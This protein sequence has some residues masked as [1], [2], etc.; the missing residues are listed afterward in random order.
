[1]QNSKWD[2]LILCLTIISAAALIGYCIL[3]G[4][5]LISETIRAK[6]I[7][8]SS[9]GMRD[10]RPS[11]LGQLDKGSLKPGSKRVKGVSAAGNALKGNPKAGVL[12]VEFSDFQCPFSK[13]F[14]QEVL[15]KIEKEYIASSKVK[16]AYRDFP[17]AFHSQAKLAAMACECAGK[18]GKYWP[19]FDK[20]STS[21]SLEKDALRGFAKGIG[22]QEA[23]FNKCLDNEETKAEV[24]KDMKDALAYG[25]QG[26]PAF[27]VNGRMIEGALPFD[28]FK[29]II[30]EELGAG[31]VKR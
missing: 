14:Y 27:F 29:M 10:L 22:L 8:L 28:T 18:Q 25:V 13:R 4:A 20:L 19:M 23:L 7:R 2:N 17:L 3:S 16:F 9:A 1:V 12:I 15:P 30:D 21:A 26:T 11:N 5:R 31:K 24:E 6:E